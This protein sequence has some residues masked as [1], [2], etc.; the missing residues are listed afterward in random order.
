MLYES[1][2]RPQ[3]SYLV[4]ELRTHHAGKRVFVYPSTHYIIEQVL[5][6][7]GVD[8]EIISVSN[9]LYG[10]VIGSY[11]HDTK[12]ADE[13]LTLNEYPE[14][15]P[16]LRYKTLDQKIAVFRFLLELGVSHEKR[17]RVM[18][19]KQLFDTLLN[20]S[21]KY[22]ERFSQSFK[23]LKST[24]QN[25]TSFYSM[26]LAELLDNVGEN[27]VVIYAPTLIANELDRMSKFLT[28]AANF[29]F[30]NTKLRVTPDDQRAELEL[31]NN[32]GCQVYF[33][34]ITHY[35]NN[36]LAYGLGEI[37][38]YKECFLH[39]YSAN[40]T[41]RVWTNKDAGTANLVS[42]RVSEK[43]VYYK[44]ADQTFE[45]TQK[46][47]IRLIKSDFA[48]VNHYKMKWTEKAK[49]MR[50]ASAEHYL[51]FADDC[52]I[53]FIV[54]NTTSTA[55]FNTHMKTNNLVSVIGDSC[56]LDT[57]YKFLSKLLVMISTTEE[58]LKMCDDKYLWKHFGFTTI[59]YS[60]HPVSMKYRGIYDLSHR[61]ELDDSY[62]YRNKLVYRKMSKFIPTIK[63]AYK[64]WL[65]K[66]GT[67]YRNEGESGSLE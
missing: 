67:A 58:I 51:V 47:R 18:Y 45:F 34:T 1:F 36:K 33:P 38:G 63:Q 50:M 20:Q 23:A 32:A 22:I 16:L 56:V 17:H 4:K 29:P 64:Q 24:L 21:E 7:G 13:L 35:K 39:N 65:Q 43:P 19:H 49:L 40:D 5:L 12:T 26:P 55:S 41:Y 53:G 37:N 44:I 62:D 14:F 11:I 27:D 59:A 52:L 57:K 66:Y 28:F 2:N 61:Q 6:N 42:V 15:E 30:E 3:L 60:N 46:T 48:T 9:N 10:R 25:K 54:F 31:L 8:A